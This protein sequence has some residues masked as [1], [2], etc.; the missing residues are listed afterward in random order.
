MPKKLRAERK[1]SSY[2]RIDAY[3][4]QVWK[5]NK[6]YLQEKIEDYG[7]LYKNGK[8]QTKEEIFYSVVKEKWKERSFDET[9]GR[10]IRNY[11]E[12]IDQAQRSHLI[13]Q[14]THYQ[15]LVYDT[16]TEDKQSSIYKE[17]RRILK[18][19]K[20]DPDNIEYIGEQTTSAGDEQ[21]YEYAY[22]TYE[23]YQKVATRGKNK[24]HIIWAKREVEK[25]FYIIHHISQKAGGGGWDEII[26][27]PTEEM[28]KN[29]KL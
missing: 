13:T 12:A 5:A 4:K 19:R 2:K 3:L 15:E 28:M 9:L 11:D 1:A 8:L 17:M 20:F 10:K 18:N 23:K 26:E 16:V 14:K 22:K 6:D 7:G 27:F 25:K 29:L 21:W 24:G